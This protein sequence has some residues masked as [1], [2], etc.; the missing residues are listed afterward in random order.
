MALKL[1][2]SD[3]WMNYIR[4]LTFTDKSKSAAIFFYADSDGSRSVPMMFM[5]MTVNRM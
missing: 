5:N 4:I 1:N 2:Q 3:L